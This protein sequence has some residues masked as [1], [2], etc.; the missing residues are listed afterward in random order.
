MKLF[1]RSFILCLI[2]IIPS[3]ASSSEDE[4]LQIKSIKFTNPDFL[5][6]PGLSKSDL[7]LD[8]RIFQGSGI[9]KISK[10]PELVKWTVNFETQDPSKSIS[11]NIYDDDGALSLMVFYAIQEEDIK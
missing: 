2:L 5:L 8:V 7:L 3:Y 11:L 10:I 6:K 9:D 4:N 1:L